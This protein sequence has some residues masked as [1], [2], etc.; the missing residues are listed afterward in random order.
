MEIAKSVW[1]IIET[2]IQGIGHGTV[3][4]IVQDGRLIQID[5]T[6]KIR[7]VSDSPG[8][9]RKIAK[10]SEDPQLTNLRLRIG[11]ALA[12]LQYGQIVIVIKNHQITQIERLEKYRVGAMEGLF[13]EGI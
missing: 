11:K 5:K 7:L 6:E 4:L 9:A 2:E 12:E 10:S 8:K 1:Q 13:G 3:T